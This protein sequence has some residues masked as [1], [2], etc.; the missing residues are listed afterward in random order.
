MEKLYN[1]QRKMQEIL[2]KYQKNR[3]KIKTAE[4]KS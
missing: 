3:R 1:K 4:Q 2:N